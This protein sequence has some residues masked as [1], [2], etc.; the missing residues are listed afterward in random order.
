MTNTSLNNEQK[1][2]Q[3]MIDIGIEYTSLEY[4]NMLTLYRHETTFAE[5]QDELEKLV[6]EIKQEELDYIET[7]L[8]SGI[9]CGSEAYNETL[10]AYRNYQSIETSI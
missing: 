7:M 1:F 9:E 10:A 8:D 4:T 5:K 2:I 6:A 3:T